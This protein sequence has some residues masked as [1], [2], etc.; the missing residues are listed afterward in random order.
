MNYHHF[1]VVF[2]IAS[3]W[4]F[5]LGCCVPNLIVDRRH[6]YKPCELKKYFKKGV[7]MNE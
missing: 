2:K 1:H 4:R 3:F 7:E 6:A 5:G